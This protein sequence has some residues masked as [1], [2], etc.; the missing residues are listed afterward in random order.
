MRLLRA[1]SNQRYMLYGT[2]LTVPLGLTRALVTQNMHL[3]DE[4]ESD[5]DDDDDEDS[6]PATSNKVPTCLPVCKC[7]PVRLHALL[8]LG[9]RICMSRPGTRGRCLRVY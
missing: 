5:D 7:A 9:S 1:V 8:L 2:F 6:P 4:G 3:L